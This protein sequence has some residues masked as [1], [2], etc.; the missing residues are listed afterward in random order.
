MQ[1]SMQR[2]SKRQIMRRAR[3]ADSDGI[4]DRSG[5]IRNGAFERDAAPCRTDDIDEGA[6]LRRGFKM[7]FTRGREGGGELGEIAQRGWIISDNG[8]M[9]MRHKHRV[10]EAGAIAQHRR[11]PVAQRRRVR[12]VVARLH[13]PFDAARIRKRAD[14]KRRR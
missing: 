1:K 14:W 8:T 4:D 2:R 12:Y 3:D 6:P 9:R 13:R 10:A 11:E 5:A 7:P